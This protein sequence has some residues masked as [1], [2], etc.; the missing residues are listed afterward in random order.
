MYNDFNTTDPNTI[1][2]IVLIILLIIV[3]MP[4]LIYL[5]YKIKIEIK[6]R[7]YLA[8]KTRMSELE[9]KHNNK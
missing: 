7:Y 3:L 5:I 8:I 1:N 4:F 6:A 9:E 2:L